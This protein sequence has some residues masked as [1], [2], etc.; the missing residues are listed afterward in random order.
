MRKLVFDLEF[1]DEKA[2]D[3]VMLY[4]VTYSKEFQ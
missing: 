4:N 3:N 2:E 1:V